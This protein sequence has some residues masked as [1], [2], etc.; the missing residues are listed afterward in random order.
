M[1]R[2]LSILCVG[3]LLGF[4]SLYGNPVVPA[5]NVGQS[6]PPVQTQEQRVVTAIDLE[7]YKLKYQIS[8]FRLMSQDLRQQKSKAA[9]SKSPLGQQLQIRIDQVEKYIVSLERYLST[10]EYRKGLA[11]MEAQQRK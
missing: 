8:Q 6:P 9:S 4:N 10:L 11:E 1:K 7:I 2:K 3:F 5:I